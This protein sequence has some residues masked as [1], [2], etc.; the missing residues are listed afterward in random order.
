M[1]FSL[2]C[3]V[4]CEKPL[5]RPHLRCLFCLERRLYY[6]KIDRDD[7]VKIRAGTQMLVATA[8]APDVIPKNCT[9]YYFLINNNGGS[10]KRLIKRLLLKWISSVTSALANW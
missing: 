3:K 5:K 6:N 1:D 7:Y 8:T 4:L 2:P 9:R 10:L